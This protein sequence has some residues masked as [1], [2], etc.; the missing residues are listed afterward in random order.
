MSKCRR[1]LHWCTAKGL[2]PFAKHSP[3]HNAVLLQVFVAVTVI[4]RVDLAAVM[5]AK[6]FCSKVIE[7]DKSSRNV[8][9]IGSIPLL[10]NRT[11]EM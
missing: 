2:N 9:C 6:R 3:L 5:K 4:N 11:H 10:T 8:P 7:N 1:G